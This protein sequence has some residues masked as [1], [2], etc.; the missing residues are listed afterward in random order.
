MALLPVVIC[1]LQ[2]ACNSSPSHPAKELPQLPEITVET[3]AP[4][5]R[6]ELGEAYRAAQADLGNPEA[7]GKLGMLLQAHEQFASAET[8][9]RRAHLLDPDS[10]RWRYY[11]GIVL[12]RQG[13]RG[14]A[15]EVFRGALESR[16][17]FLPLRI[18]LADAIYHTGALN[19]SR[20]IYET[21]LGEQPGLAEA[22]YGLGRVLSAQNDLQGALPYLQKACE[23]APDFGT[24]HYA[25]ALAYRDLGRLEES[26]AHL[27]VYEKNKTTT[28]PLRDP[29][30]QAVQ[31]LNDSPQEHLSRGVELEAAG[32]IEE[33][34]REHERAL[35][36]DPEFAQAHGNLLTL[37]ARLGRLDKAEEHYQSARKI[38]RNRE[39]LHYN[40]GVLAF[41]HG[42]YRQAGEAFRR[43]LEISPRYAEAHTNLGQ[44]LEKEGRFDEALRHYRRAVASKPNYRLAHFHLGRMLLVK[45]RSQEAI[46][47]FHKTLTPE[48]EKTPDF[49]YALAAAYARSGRAAEA[50]RYGRQAEQLATSQGQD[51]LAA[52]I[53]ADLRKLEPSGGVP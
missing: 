11:L 10:F 25:L 21:I 38:N 48:D 6:D 16:S 15:A 45:A 50:L 47:A 12:A 24:A 51:A 20:E 35:E 19:E 42:R 8:C 53:R 32:R 14:P 41:E 33:A 43:A 34:I 4:A 49:L 40:Y 9:Y 46:E 1:W 37:Y 17:E 31:R 18:R 27:A 5:I 7:N 3:F 28:P 26:A 29:L 13:K 36:M 52:T 39:E 2:V 23:L 44:V 30:L 22:L